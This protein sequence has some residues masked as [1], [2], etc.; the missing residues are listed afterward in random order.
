MLSG[1]TEAIV[2]VV[3]PRVEAVL[4]QVRKDRS[5]TMIFL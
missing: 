2:A 4:V 5:M 3:F 1:S